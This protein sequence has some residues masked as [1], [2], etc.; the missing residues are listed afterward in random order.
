MIT[1]VGY[2]GSPL[3]P[4]AQQRLAGAS[5]VV[6]GAR[7]LE[8]VDGGRQFVMGDVSAALDEVQATDGD[9][10]V[11]ASGDPAL[12]GILRVMR[13][14]GMRPEVLPAVSSIAVAFARIGLPWDDAAAL[15]VHGRDP[16]HAVNACRALPKTAVLTSPRFGPAELGRALDRLAPRAGRGRSPGYA[17]RVDH[18]V[19]PG[20]GRRRATGPIR[21]WSWCSTTAGS[22]A[23]SAP[24]TSP[25][26]RHRVG[27]TP[28]P[29]TGT[30]TAW[31]PNGR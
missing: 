26:H 21:T 31:S 16:R 5:L 23:V 18:Q 3:S 29:A 22:V 13:E 6:G 30:A 4:Q 2:D 11:M 14:R 19:H 28:T 17:R 9:T 15:S 8:P 27:H 1:V 24:T 12:F 20:R 10:V 7:N 25:P